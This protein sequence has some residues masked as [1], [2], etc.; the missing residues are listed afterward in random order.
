MPISDELKAIYVTAPVDDIYIETLTLSH[1]EI[2]GTVRY[3]TNNRDGWPAKLENGDDVLYTYTPFGV[4]PPDKAEQAN[5]SLKV[6]IDN[7]SRNLMDE[8][9]ALATQPTE[10]IAV[11]Y[12]VY[13]LS[14]PNTVQN[15]PPL[16]LEVL[17]VTATEQAISF[18]A[19][20]TNL[21]SK[22]FPS[23]LYSPEKFPGLVR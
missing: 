23:E 13:L 2:T 8:L 16:T 5:L 3:I 7:T 14:D 4:V 17:S 6:A 15:D 21:R 11:I 20:I 12:R 10:P 18:N 19:G 9:E 1:P 22:P